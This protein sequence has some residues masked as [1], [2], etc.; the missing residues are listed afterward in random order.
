[1][2]WRLL[3]EEEAE[4]RKAMEI[5]GEEGGELLVALRVVEAK[6]GMVPSLRGQVVEEACLPGYGERRGTT[7]VHEG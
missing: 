6:K 5:H 7:L 1:M 4:I 3:D 2:R